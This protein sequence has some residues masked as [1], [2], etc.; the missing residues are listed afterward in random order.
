MKST[1]GNA[2]LFGGVVL[3]AL[4]SALIIAAPGVKEDS[5]K[6]SQAEQD[7]KN[8]APAVIVRE[9][10]PKFEPFNIVYLARENNNSKIFKSGQDGSSPKL[11]YNDAKDNDKL[12]AVV[13]IKND[14]STIYLVVGAP[15]QEFSGKLTE[16]TTD[17]KAKAKTLQENLSFT[18]PPTI[19][20][21]GDK[22]AIISFSN[23]EASFGFTVLLQN[24]DGS[25]SK[26]IYKTQETISI[27]NFSNDG[28]KLAI[29]KAS[30]SGGSQVVIADL[31]SNTAAGIYSTTGTI[32]SI[33]Y[34]INA[35]VVSESP[36]GSNQANNTEIIKFDADGKNVT[37][38]TTNQLSENS[39]QFDPET[40]QIAYI[41]LTYTDGLTVP[42]STGNLVRLDIEKKTESIV[43]KATGVIGWTR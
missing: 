12:K 2:F 17:G 11:L 13:G 33:D 40:K 36:A 28:K 27:L 32:L 4:V 37:K 23:D 14:G 29:V 22:I 8:D 20:P 6:T 1:T 7:T 41:Q 34:E 38:L 19:S 24:L 26:A 9:A 43:G 21:V 42:N 35:V 3:L 25:D 18:A 31:N 10:E 39:V 16:I 5:P 15:E 30:P